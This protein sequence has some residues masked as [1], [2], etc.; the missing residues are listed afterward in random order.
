VKRVVTAALVGMLL[1]ALPSVAAHAARS[2][3]PKKPAASWVKVSGGPR[4]YWVYTPSGRAPYRGRALV[5]Y[6]H[7]CT[8]GDPEFEDQNARLAFGTRWNGLAEEKNFVVAYP[9]QRT[10]DNEHPEA[11]EGN[12]GTCWNWFIEENQHR[13]QGEP[14]MIA[15]ITDAVIASRDVDPKRVYVAG[16]SAGAD[17]S[18]IMAATYPDKYKAMADAL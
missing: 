18:V 16:A 8:Q 11:L 17:M 7:G 4:D 13:G 5:V 12:S 3:A 2:K 15:D 14:K 10:F 1:T 9:I 6:L